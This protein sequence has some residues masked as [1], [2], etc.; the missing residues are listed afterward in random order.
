MTSLDREWF[1]KAREESNM[2]QEDIA[3]KVGVTRQHI[4]M[5]ENGI[6][7]PSTELAKKLG[8]ILGFSWTKFYED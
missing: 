5:I 2:T 7:N 3:K 1:K 6:T 8:N 4:G